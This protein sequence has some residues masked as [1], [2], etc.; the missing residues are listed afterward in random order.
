[1]NPSH[2]MHPTAYARIFF[3]AFSNGLRGCAVNLATIA[4]ALFVVFALA[5]AA[6]AQTTAPEFLFVGQSV[7]GQSGNVP[8]IA[9]YTVNTTT[10]ALAP[11]A[12]APVQ[13]RGQGTGALAIN[14]A[15]T[16]LFG[17]TTNSAGQ[18]AVEVFNIASDGS[19]T[20]VANSPF[21][22]GQAQALL[23]LIAVSPNGN[24]LYAASEMPGDETTPQS[25]IVQVFAIA[26][27]GSLTLNNTFAY[28]A[29]EA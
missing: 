3:Q 17:T 28:A 26:A 9:T 4:F 14:L 13:T 11:I 27:D 12:A 29:V 10:G 8:G 20:E 5:P 1:M 19:L 7:P 2:S 16:E 15:G 18:G 6:G 25:T 22:I 23:Q 24:F 21:G